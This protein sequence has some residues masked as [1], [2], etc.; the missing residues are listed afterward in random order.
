MKYWIIKRHLTAYLKA[1]LLTFYIITIIL[2][3][4]LPLILTVVS[5]N[6]W[7]LTIYIFTVPITFMNDHLD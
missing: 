1:L 6:F 2:L 7:F 4:S 3:A 5:G